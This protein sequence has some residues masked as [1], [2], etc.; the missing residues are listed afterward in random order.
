MVIRTR[1]SL[2]PSADLIYYIGIPSMIVV[3]SNISL[4]ANLIVYK[5]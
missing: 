4:L 1:V 5:H 2:S 3:L